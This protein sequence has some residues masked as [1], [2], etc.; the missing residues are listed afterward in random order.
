MRFDDLNFKLPF[1]ERWYACVVLTCR[2]FI[3]SGRITIQGP[4]VYADLVGIAAEF[5][6]S[7]Q[8]TARAQG[9]AALL[10]LAL[11]T[12]VWS[13]LSVKLGKRPVY[14]ACTIIMF[15]GAMLCSFGELHPLLDQSPVSDTF[16]LL[17]HFLAKDFNVMLGTRSILRVN[18][19]A[20]R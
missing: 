4:L 17:S 14:L 15:A 7:V 5:D 19:R 1:V 13:V 6:R 12:V 8:A 9:S 2:L 10:A 3:Y 16:A 11:A 18:S 20:W